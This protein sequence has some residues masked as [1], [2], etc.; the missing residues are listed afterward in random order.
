MPVI[1]VFAILTFIS[2]LY[3]V[4]IPLSE[5]PEMGRIPASKIVKTVPGGYVMRYDPDDVKKKRP[6]YWEASGEK[7]RLKKFTEFPK[8]DSAEAALLRICRTIDFLARDRGCS[9][10]DDPRKIWSF[11]TDG[12]EETG[13]LSKLKN[14]DVSTTFSCLDGARYGKWLARSIFPEEFYSYKYDLRN[15]DEN[16][17][18]PCG[19]MDIVSK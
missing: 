1:A 5:K 18:D 10:A 17:T 12:T 2:V 3:M 14:G 11:L 19:Y 7:A 8:R 9:W 4:I 13:S 6:M 16:G 15:L